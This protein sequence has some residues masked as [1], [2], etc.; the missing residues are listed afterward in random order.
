MKIFEDVTLEDYITL[1]DPE[2]LWCK[3][4]LNFGLL[5]TLIC[6]KGK[7]AQ[8]FPA[9]RMELSQG[10]EPDRGPAFEYHCLTLIKGY[11][12]HPVE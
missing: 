8:L 2:R 10:P 3:P 4:L 1:N 6:R 9:L 7:M 5:I 12:T 11:I